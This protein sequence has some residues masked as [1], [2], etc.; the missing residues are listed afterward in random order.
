MRVRFPHTGLGGL[1][2]L[3]CGAATTLGACA[4][5]EGIVQQAR[6]IAPAAVGLASDARSPSE[7][8]F[9]PDWW[10]RFDD[11]ELTGQ[12]ERALE[13]NPGLKAARARVARADALARLAGATAG[14]Q[15]NASVDATRQR[16]SANSI[17][18]PPLGGSTQTVASA[19]LGASWEL[20]FFGRN[21]A[22]IGAAIGAGRA[23]RAESQASRIALA[24]NV[25]RTWVQLS[26][27][28]AQREVASRTLAQREE[29]LDLIRRRVRGGLDTMVELRQGEGALPE[30]RQ[31]IEELDE[32]IVLTRHALAALSGRGPDAADAVAPRLA[33]IRM[34]ELPSVIPADLIGRR[35]DV[36][37]ARWQ[38]EALSS[39]VKGARAQFYPNVDL[40]AF[41]GLAS[42]GL[43][44][45]VDA[46]SRQ[47]GVG[48]AIR[49]PIFD[50]GRLRA[51]LG[52][53][54]AEL[55]AAI[56]RYNGAVIDAVH[57]AA[58]QLS[59][60]K[61]LA[62]QRAEQASAQAAAESAWSL[63]KQRYG[64]GLATY[65]VV[66]N[67]EASLLNQRRLQVDLKARTLDAQIA[68]IG[69]LG[70]GFRPE[71]PDSAAPPPPL[72]PAPVSGV[73]Q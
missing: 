10:A 34:L 59:T 13:G 3:A 69:A 49:L 36:T 54:T 58:D 25:A 19:Q 48:P 11:A 6:P 50:G 31:R 5:S 67:A 24:G 26:R 15:V 73:L 40:T 72:P 7:P 71:A 62:V 51:N 39:D 21:A 68:L 2:A 27:L 8:A 44:R 38:L 33:S 47:W 64:A 46:G 55:D 63:A 16:Y 35:A 45:L 53:K 30:T 4:S 22:A 66:L 56:E 28:L 32:Q 65:L 29:I 23:A 60:L 37:A 1:V 41:A 17:V 70:G 20:D 42:L 14:P 12:I 18:P 61:S 52:A 9:A 57:Q 43:D